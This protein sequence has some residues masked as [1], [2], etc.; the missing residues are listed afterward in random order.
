MTRSDL[1]KR[2][3][4]ANPH[5]YAR[6]IEGIVDTVFEQIVS[7]LEHG[8]RVELRGFGAFSTRSRPA[9]VGRNPRTGHEVAVPGK[10]VPHFKP[11]KEL[12]ERL[13]L[14]DGTAADPRQPLSHPV[15]SGGAAPNRAAAE[16]LPP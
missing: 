7:A 13:N 9:R 4:A 15:V 1:I 6:D 3:V 10:V 12:R 2:L 8:Y 5:L 14:R 11:G 16:R